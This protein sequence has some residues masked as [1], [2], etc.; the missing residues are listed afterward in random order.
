M[1]IDDADL[2]Q[3]TVFEIV[4]SFVYH[5]HDVVDDF[6]T[7]YCDTVALLDRTKWVEQGYHDHWHERFHAFDFISKRSAMAF[8]EDL[9]MGKDSLQEAYKADW[10]KSR[11]AD[12]ASEIK[13][14]PY[15]NEFC[16]QSQ[17]LMYLHQTGLDESGT[18]LGGWIDGFIILPADYQSLVVD[19]L[20]DPALLECW[21]HAFSRH[22]KLEYS[23]N[24]NFIH[25]GTFEGSG[26]C[27]TSV[28]L[29]VFNHTEDSQFGE[30]KIAKGETF[31]HYRVSHRNY[32]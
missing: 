13:R 18:C 12:D 7:F 6:V 22:L 28:T 3:A 20:R 2:K 1:L 8:P 14:L 30:V 10:A 31:I 32:A 26:K 21:P 9:W 5:G 17:M 23:T 25:A 15:K 19:L 29:S 11:K 4:K 27:G 24:S 16:D